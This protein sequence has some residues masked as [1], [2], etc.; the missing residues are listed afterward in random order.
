VGQGE[1]QQGYYSREDIKEVIAYAARL[2]I[3]VIPEVD[4]PG[5]SEAALTAIPNTPASVPARVIPTTG[6]TPTIF[7]AGKDSVMAFLKD[8]LG[9]VCQLFPGQYI[10]LGGDEAPKDN[11][12]RCPDCQRRMAQ[13]HLRDSHGLQMWMA[14]ELAKYVAEKGKNAHLLR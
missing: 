12:D 10:H 8:V 2:G 3:T 1:G 4:L 9:E 7:C 13:Q 11:W 6:F 14:A 5:H